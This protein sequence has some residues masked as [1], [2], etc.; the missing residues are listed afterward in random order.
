MAMA[1]GPRRMS[2]EAAKM[3]DKKI[4]VAA[5]PLHLR[6]LLAYAVQTGRITDESA[7]AFSNGVLELLRDMISE[8]TH[9]EST[10]V[11]E[12]RGEEL[13]LSCLF[14]L[15]AALLA[16]GSSQS[17]LELLC[18]TDAES[19]Y[20]L[21]NQR[22]RRYHWEAARLYVQAKA[23]RLEVSN[24]YYQE[25][26]DRECRQMLYGYDRRFAAHRIACSPDYPLAVQGRRQQGIYYIYRYMRYLCA[27]NRFCAEYS[28]SELQRLYDR[29]CAAHRRRHYEERVNLYSLVLVNALMAEYLQKDPGCLEIT[30]DECEVAEI[31][32]RAFSPPEREE[33]LNQ[34]AARL[35]GGEREYNLRV[36][37][38]IMPGL[39]CS[40][41]NE[42]LQ[43]FLVI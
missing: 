21:G 9:G 23:V 18:H 13:L 6:T 38:R 30:S 37:Q 32:L 19:L 43:N 26:L 28:A 27:E 40:I 16:T 29:F 4:G 7:S 12:E 3:Q 24:R 10:S 15:D 34:T 11:T 22:I 5:E 41:E 39:L 20:H 14:T 35:L 33:I 36:V 31:L 42:S 17:A 2:A 25:T 8:Y 1:A